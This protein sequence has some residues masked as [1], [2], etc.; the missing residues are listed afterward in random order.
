MTGR[1]R[2]NGVLYEEVTLNESPVRDFTRQDYRDFSASDL[3]DGSSPRR[4]DSDTGEVSAIISGN[5][6]DDPFDDGVT[7][8]LSWTMDDGREGF[9]SR[10]FDDL[11][12]AERTFDGL[13]RGLDSVGPETLSRKYNLKD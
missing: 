1:I 13:V 9:S 7:V 8:C 3:P 6:G 11:R 4:A 12:S 2:V 10:R 5:L